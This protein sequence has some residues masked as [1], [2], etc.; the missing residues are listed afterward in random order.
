MRYELGC[1]QY[2]MTFDKMLYYEKLVSFLW[3]LSTSVVA[4]LMTMVLMSKVQQ[5]KKLTAIPLNLC[6]TLCK[7]EQVPKIQNPSATDRIKF[8]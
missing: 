2:L 6:C 4:V 8:V 5:E 1:Y 7:S 3:S